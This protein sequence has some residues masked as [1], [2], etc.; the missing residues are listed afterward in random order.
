MKHDEA[1]PHE[2]TP[3]T[4]GAPIIGRGVLGRLLLP[5]FIIGLLVT[6]IFGYSLLAAHRQPSETERFIPEYSYKH[7]VQLDYIVQLKPNSLFGETTLGSG[8]TYFAKIIDGI[9]V[10]FSYDFRGEPAN[11]V[12]G[13]YEIRAILVSGDLSAELEGKASKSTKLWE[14]ASVVVPTTPF[15]GQ[16]GSVNIK[17]S[18][19]LMLQD[20]ESEAKAISEEL[21]IAPRQLYVK[22]LGLVKTSASLSSR[23]LS[24]KELEASLVVPLGQSYF[25]L[26]SKQASAEDSIGKTERVVLTDVLEKRAGVLRSTLI[27]GSISGVFGI[28]MLIR[29]ALQ[30]P[31]RKVQSASIVPR[32][33]RDRV[34]EASGQA[35]IL[36][37][38]MVAVMSFEDLVKIAD[39]TGKP[40]VHHATADE[41]DAREIFYVYDGS[42]RYAYLHLR[43]K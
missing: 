8:Q 17:Q 43:K 15:A 37:G 5:L 38:D 2:K 34:A 7:D 3:A 40:I 32:R 9:D 19:P 14:K 1:L 20:F 36:A 41:S 28:L 12:K 42:V 16:S 22:L 35:N 31:R 18:L 11:D 29:F 10:L 39:E 21:G 24:A 25:T 33:F 26:T 4:D 27:A 6:A 30:P 23:E 13:T